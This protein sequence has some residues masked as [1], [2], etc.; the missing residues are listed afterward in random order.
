VH[1]E[2]NAN[3]AGEVARRR[4]VQDV[5]D[6][7]SAKGDEP[8]ASASAEEYD[9]IVINDM[10][11]SGAGKTEKSKRRT[12][13]APRPERDTKLPAVISV[14]LDEDEDVEWTW[15]HTA[16][17]KSVVTGYIITKRTDKPRQRREVL[18]DSTDSSPRR[19]R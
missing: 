19:R 2:T 16:D 13:Y 5:Q 1:G 10:F 17:G 15:T 6:G 12:V 4:A 8:I 14:Q 18:D 3:V 7:Q 11:V 9:Y